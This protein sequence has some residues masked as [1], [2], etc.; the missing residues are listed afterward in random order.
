M[1]DKIDRNHVKTAEIMCIDLLINTTVQ[2][3]KQ[4]NSSS[5]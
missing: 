5:Y 4:I 2:A 3:K 1:Y